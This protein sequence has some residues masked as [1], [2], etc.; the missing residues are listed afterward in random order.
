MSIIVHKVMHKV[1]GDCSGVVHA[2][3]LGAV[4]TQ[5]QLLNLFTHDLGQM[6]CGRLLFTNTA[7][8]KI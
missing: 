2:L 8:H 6:Y 7:L 4:L 5:I 3:G 1:R